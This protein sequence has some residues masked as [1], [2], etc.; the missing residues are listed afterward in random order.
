[1]GYVSKKVVG[2][3]AQR[4]LLVLLL[5]VSMLGAIVPGSTKTTLAASPPTVTTSPASNIADT[6]ASLNG[7]LAFWGTAATVT[8]SFVIPSARK[9]VG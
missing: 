2:F 8:V 3:M 9:R 7:Y 4:G 5:L 1:M 6:S